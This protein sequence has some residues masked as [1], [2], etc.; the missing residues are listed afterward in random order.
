VR[1][2]GARPAVADPGAPHPAAGLDFAALSTPKDTRGLIE[3]AVRG[4]LEQVPALRPL[5]LVVGLE[6]RGRGD[7]QMYRVELPGPVVVRD[8]A[9]DAR[10]RLEV[11]RPTFN[12][13][14]AENSLRRW[15]R[16][17]ERGEMKAT[18]VEQILRLI[19]QVVA[20]QEERNRLRKARG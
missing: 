10:V 18:G 2:A 9:A 13:L 15:R 14:V 7:V 12:E 4:F 16:A 1:A 20:K 5:R 19:A 17:I 3:Q 6:L 8:I 11:P